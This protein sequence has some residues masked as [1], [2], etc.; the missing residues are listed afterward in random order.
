[1][2]QSAIER[3]R[4]PLRVLSGPGRQNTRALRDAEKPRGYEARRSPKLC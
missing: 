2:H 4:E 3:E 1:M